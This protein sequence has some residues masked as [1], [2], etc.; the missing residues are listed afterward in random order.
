MTVLAFAL[1]LA[2]AAQDDGAAVKTWRG[3]GRFCGYATSLQV[4]R[5]E[6]LEPTAAAVEAAG[7]RWSGRFG[8]IE[9][10]EVNWAARP[11]FAGTALSSAWRRHLYRQKLDTGRWQYTLWDGGS[12]VAKLTGDRFDGSARDLRL[13]DRVALVDRAGA[14]ERGCRFRLVY[15]P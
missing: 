14:R 13:V 12:L 7:Y 5:G 8:T 1:M 15:A 3:P 10:A 9:V 2:L 6:T 11:K 4:A